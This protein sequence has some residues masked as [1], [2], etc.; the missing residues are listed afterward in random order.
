MYLLIARAASIFMQ[1]FI[2][3]QEINNASSDLAQNVEDDAETWKEEDKPLFQPCL[4][5]IKVL[6]M[7]FI[8]IEAVY[9]NLVI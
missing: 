6:F 4:G 8:Q 3:S 7:Y 1:I 5:L 9:S 2:F